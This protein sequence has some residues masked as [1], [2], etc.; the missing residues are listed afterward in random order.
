MYFYKQWW[1]HWNFA[2]FSH[3]NKKIFVSLILH[4]GI[5]EI[6]P[7]PM[8]RIM[9]LWSS[10]EIW[11]WWLSP[12][13]FAPS[14]RSSGSRFW[15]WTCRARTM[16]DNFVLAS[17]NVTWGDTYQFNFPIRWTTIVAPLI[18]LVT[19]ESPS[20]W[21]KTKQQISSDLIHANGILFQEPEVFNE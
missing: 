5:L 15:P 8:S 4:V 18:K 2:G 13:P 10:K 1:C 6:I 14:R 17:I 3:R 9:S 12:V 16:P 20:V 11:E 7:N 21:C 19:H